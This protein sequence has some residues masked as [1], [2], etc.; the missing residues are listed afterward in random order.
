MRNGCLDDLEGFGKFAH[1]GG[2]HTARHGGWSTCLFFFAGV[3]RREDA[4]SREAM[5][6]RSWVV[7]LS[8]LNC[9]H[10][11]LHAKECTAQHHA[12]REPNCCCRLA[13]EQPS[14]PSHYNL[15]L[16]LGHGNRCLVS[17]SVRPDRECGI[18]GRDSRLSRDQLGTERSPAN[19]NECVEV[20]TAAI[21]YVMTIRPSIFPAFMFSK[22]VLM[23]SSLVL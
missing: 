13:A 23:S 18:R 16:P 19:A 10:R 15:L 6:A 11:A 14:E 4:P 1:Q 20:M 7:I 22:T 3:E 17:A 12:L 2:F 8:P 21:Q 5:I 9:R